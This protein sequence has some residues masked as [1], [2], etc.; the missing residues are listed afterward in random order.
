M[1]VELTR[2]PVPHSRRFATGRSCAECLDDAVWLRSS[3]RSGPNTAVV[4]E[5]S[6]DVAEFCFEVGSADCEVL[7]EGERLV[8]YVEIS[9]Q[10][11]DRSGELL[12][13]FGRLGDNSLRLCE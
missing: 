4:V 5:S 7:L 1:L 10:A 2:C 11:T 8:G 13:L 9:L 6:G 3:N 12:Q